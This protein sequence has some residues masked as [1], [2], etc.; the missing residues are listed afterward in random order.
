MPNKTRRVDKL[1]S[2]LEHSCRHEPGWMGERALD[3][4]CDENDGEE[5]SKWA[6]DSRCGKSDGGFEDSRKTLARSAAL[7]RV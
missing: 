4:R 2:Q 5:G 6:P 3:S 7:W 1:T